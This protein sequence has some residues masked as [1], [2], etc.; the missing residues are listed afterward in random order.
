[1]KYNVFIFCVFLLGVVAVSGKSTGKDAK[2]KSESA[3]VTSA[4]GAG[5]D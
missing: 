2:D 3:S 4:T 5:K 1:M